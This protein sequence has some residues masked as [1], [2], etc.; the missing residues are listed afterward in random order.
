MRRR[1][2]GPLL[3]V[4]LVL[5]ALVMPLWQ[6]MDWREA[7]LDQEHLQVLLFETASFQMEL[8]GSSVGE[9]AKVQTTEQL[10]EW[11]RAVYSTA[12]THERFAQSGSALPSKLA[13][14]DGLLQWI[15]RVQ[16][17]GA[18]Q[19][20]KEET[21]LLAEVAQSYKPLQEAYS[22]M[23]NQKGELAGGSVDKVKKLDAQLA[24]MIRKN[25][26]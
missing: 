20:T 23:M 25:L 14:L 17:G 15:Q 21:G 3:M 8:L 1:L 16:I 12:Y 9:A 7:R 11:K 18:R 19:L 10:N 4:L 13:S 2:M 24:E 22:S 26:K 6:L 5:L